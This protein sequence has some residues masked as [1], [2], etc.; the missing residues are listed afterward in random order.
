MQIFFLLMQ[1]ILQISLLLKEFPVAVQVKWLPCKLLSQGINCP[2]SPA[3]RSWVPLKPSNLMNSHHLI[4][5]LSLLRSAKLPFILSPTSDL[6][7]FPPPSLQ[8]RRLRRSWRRWTLLTRCM[9][10]YE[11]IWVTRPR[12]RTLPSS[13]WSA[14]PNKMSTNK[15]LC[16]VSSRKISRFVQMCQDSEEFNIRR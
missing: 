2:Q 10:M 1:I 9:I 14:V 8:S 11:H 4:F 15:N 5:C 16:R 3:Y 13:S 6:C 12:P 7:L